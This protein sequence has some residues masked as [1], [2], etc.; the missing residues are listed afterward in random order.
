MHSISED[1]QNAFHIKTKLQ[2]WIKEDAVQCSTTFMFHCIDLIKM[3]YCID[4]EM[5][6][7]RLPG[8]SS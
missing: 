4:V 1:I 5:N 2:I 8:R 6:A 3:L 7:L